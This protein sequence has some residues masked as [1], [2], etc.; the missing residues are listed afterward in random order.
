MSP[1]DMVSVEELVSFI[2]SDGHTALTPTLSSVPDPIKAIWLHL[3][4]MEKQ[5]NPEGSDSVGS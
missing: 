3:N 2:L 5:Y 4:K 1:E